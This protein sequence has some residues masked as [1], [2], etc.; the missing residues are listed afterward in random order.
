MWMIAANLR[1]T[2]SPSRLAWS[3]GWRPPGAQSVFTKRTG[4][5][6]AMTLAIIYDITI[7]TVMAI[8]I[9]I[10][11]IIIIK[12]DLNQCYSESES[13]T[14][15]CS[16]STVVWTQFTTWMFSGLITIHINNR[17]INSVYVIGLHVHDVTATVGKTPLC[18]IWKSADAKKVILCTPQCGTEF[19]WILNV[20]VLYHQS[21]III[22]III[23]FV[24]WRLSN[25]TNTE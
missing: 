18:K 2:H 22:I 11:I 3:E 21:I 9:I 13:A 14:G 17:Q 5:T 12:S 16:R 24:Y 19:Y 1:R 15:H 7:N 6:L 20:Q 8:I 10:I 23:M 25:A 4:W